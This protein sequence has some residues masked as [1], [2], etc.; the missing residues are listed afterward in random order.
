MPTAAQARHMGVRVR[1]A[2]PGRKRWFVADYSCFGLLVWAEPAVY[3]D[4]PLAV[5][6]AIT[7][8]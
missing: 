2:T 8:F 1:P 5:W 3:L 7:R 4:Q 6:A